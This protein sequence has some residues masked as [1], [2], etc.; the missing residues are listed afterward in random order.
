MPKTLLV[1]E[2]SYR[3]S[4]HVP[5][6]AKMSDRPSVRP[7]ALVGSTCGP[8]L[9]GL[10]DSLLRVV[11]LEMVE[12]DVVELDDD[13]DDVVVALDFV[14]DVVVVDGDADVV[15]ILDD[16]DGAGAG[17]PDWVGEE[18]PAM[19]VTP[20]PRINAT[21]AMLLPPL[22]T[23]SPWHAR[24]SPLSQLIPCPPIGVTR[25]R[26]ASAESRELS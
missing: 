7:L 4:F 14:D 17:S 2:M 18:Q 12:L 26:P 20:T 6:V 3:S 21:L 5:V 23:A 16:D 1:S 11:V 24:E 15:G 25:Q 13:D 10:V 22:R 8:L 9:S 19:N